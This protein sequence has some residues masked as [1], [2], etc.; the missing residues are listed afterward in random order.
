MLVGGALGEM[1]GSRVQ[2]LRKTW[3]DDP[4]LRGRIRRRVSFVIGVLLFVFNILPAY[5]ENSLVAGG[6]YYWSAISSL[7][8]AVGAVLASLAFA[9]KPKDEPF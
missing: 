1:I 3:N 6:G 8:A 2:S 7:L 9:M 4:S 5:E